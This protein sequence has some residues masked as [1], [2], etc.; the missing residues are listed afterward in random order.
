MKRNRTKHNNI[1]I[2]SVNL[3]Q[4]TL[5]ILTF[6]DILQS[7]SVFNVELNQKNVL[8]QTKNDETLWL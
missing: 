1:Y 3:G 2:Y 8:R 6:F 4:L 7:F 5:V